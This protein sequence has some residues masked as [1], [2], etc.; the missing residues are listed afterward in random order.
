MSRQVIN[1]T[2]FIY[3]VGGL[4]HWD[5]MVG[6]SA[7]QLVLRKSNGAWNRY[8]VITLLLFLSY[9][10]K[11]FRIEYVMYHCTTTIVIIGGK[12]TSYQEV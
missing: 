1:S 6:R 3:P 9:T 4:T 5:M 2:A 8:G 10:V 7:E 12:I 11:R